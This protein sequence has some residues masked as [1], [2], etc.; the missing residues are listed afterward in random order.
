[1]VAAVLLLILFH[2]FSDLVWLHNLLEGIAAGAIGMTFSVG[3]R[4]ARHAARSNRWALLVLAL[5]FVS[6]GVLRWPLI[7]VVICVAP[8]AILVLRRRATPDA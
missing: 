3:Y 6:V 2:R 7:L 1:M 4:A 8:L 5:V